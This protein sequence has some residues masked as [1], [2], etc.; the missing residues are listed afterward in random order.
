[1][2]DRLPSLMLLVT[3]L[4]PVHERNVFPQG[5]SDLGN[6]ASALEKLTRCDWKD[7]SEKR[8]QSMWPAELSDRDCNSATCGS[9]EREDRVVNGDCECCEHF[10]FVPGN[11]SEQLENI[12]IYYSAYQRPDIV[13][14]AKKLARA[15]GLPAE[16]ATAIG[17][18]NPF[19]TNWDVRGRSQTVALMEVEIVHRQGLWVVYLNLSRHQ[20]D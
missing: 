1:M 15:L 16:Q 5:C 10:L 14:A 19:K 13:A 18:R 11:G 8:L 4:A 12:I 20:L 7:I 9:M 2:R 3:L 17:K 6:L